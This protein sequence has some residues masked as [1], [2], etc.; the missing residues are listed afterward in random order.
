MIAHD[1]EPLLSDGPIAETK[2]PDLFEGMNVVA[3]SSSS[4]RDE[5]AR[6]IFIRP[7]LSK[8][9]ETQSQN[10]HEE[11]DVIDSTFEQVRRGNHSSLASSSP[12]HYHRG[13][14]DASNIQAAQV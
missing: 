13:D 6:K 5:F 8:D 3:P 1:D 4:T 14:Y 2:E 7:N 12:A 11:Y 10:E 9:T